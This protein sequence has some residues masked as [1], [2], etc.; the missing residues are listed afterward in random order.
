[1][2]DATI[3]LLRTRR[4]ADISVHDI[5]AA[6]DMNHGLVHRWFGSKTGLL[7][8]VYDELRGRVADRIEV[9]SGRIVTDADAL[10]LARLFAWLVLDGSPPEDALATQPVRARIVE[11]ASSTWGFDEPTARL[12][13]DQAVS[14][15]LSVALFGEALGFEQGL[16][17]SIALWM[18]SVQLLARDNAATAD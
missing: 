4:V 8:A 5:A 7:H 3:E 13:A 6:A 12:L 15:V 2:V 18:R 11:I 14:L 17:A 9:D 10:L 1:M 16:D